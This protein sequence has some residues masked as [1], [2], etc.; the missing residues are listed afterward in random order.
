[1]GGVESLDNGFGYWVEVEGFKWGR[2]LLLGAFH[3]VHVN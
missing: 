3:F 1:M 2:D